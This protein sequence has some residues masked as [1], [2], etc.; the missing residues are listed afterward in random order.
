MMPIVLR[1][2]TLDIYKGEYVAFTGHS[3]CGK[4]TVL[5]LLMCM[6]PPDGG[7]LTIVEKDGSILPLTASYRRL[8]AYVPQGNQLMNGTI[9]EIVS[10]SDIKKADE[11]RIHEALR[12]ACASEFISDLKD[13]IDT[14]LGERGT[15]L[16]EG[17]MQRIAIARALYSKAPILLLD[18]ATSAL[19]GATEERLLINLRD[20][21]DKT[22]IIVTHRPAALAICDRILQFTENGIIE[23]NKEMITQVNI[24]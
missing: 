13:G 22:V 10:F 8:F 5:K 19:D 23:V 1:D 7:D 18:E 2:M 6:Y 11:Q 9:R 15:G 12:I 17:Q 16:S 14:L 3:G 24:M 4:S 20:L 21:T